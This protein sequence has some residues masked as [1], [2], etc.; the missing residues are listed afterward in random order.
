M[1]TCGVRSFSFDPVGQSPPTPVPE[2][3]LREI[4]NNNNLQTVGTIATYMYIL[5]AGFHLGGAGGHLPPLESYVPPHGICASH[6][7]T[8]WRPP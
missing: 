3:D 8:T 1:L 7:H 4:L 5:Y 2:H 6:A